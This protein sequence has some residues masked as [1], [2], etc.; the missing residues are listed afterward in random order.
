MRILFLCGSLEPGKDGVGDYTRR[1]AGALRQ[2]GVETSL[3]AIR[4]R[5]VTRPP[6][7]GGPDDTPPRIPA[8]LPRK[9][10][11]ALLEQV[12]RTVRPTHI[13]LQFV[14][15]AFA[16]KGVPF[17]LARDLRLAAGDL[18]PVWHIMFH[19]LWVGRGPDTGPGQSLLRHAQR[20]V[21]RDLLRQLRPAHVHTNLPESTEKLHALGADCRG[22]PLFSNIAADAE[23]PDTAEAE[24][25]ANPGDGA[26]RIGLFSQFGPAPPLA[27][28]AVDLAGALN[29]PVELLLIGGNPAKSGAAERE[30]RNALPETG[31]RVRATGFLDA[32]DARKAIRGCQLGLTPVPR[33]AAGKS[34]SVA[35]FLTE[36]VPV[37]MPVVL[38][39]R[40][41]DTVGFFHQRLSA[42]ILTR[43]TAAALRA[44][45]A[46][47]PACHELI[48]LASV[49]KRFLNDLA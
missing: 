44:A 22:L 7:P 3:A 41:A 42:A 31:F 49:A 4:D 28:F 37:A 43:P 15:Y 17:F 45:R 12:A 30:L 46:A 11:R 35:A 5:H 1:L 29:L 39:G 23:I 18:D 25:A 26:F 21:V 33:H 40:G 48:S 27:E 47:A 16:R 2:R 6:D 34:G 20:A 24:S 8:E 19:E 14:P 38:A 32:G 13:S 9:R 36:G 10:R